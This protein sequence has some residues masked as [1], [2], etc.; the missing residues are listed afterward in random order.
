[1]G[2]LLAAAENSMIETMKYIYGINCPNDMESNLSNS[3]KAKLIVAHVKS[4]CGVCSHANW[5]V[6]NLKKSKRSLIKYVCIYV[7]LIYIPNCSALFDFISL[8]S[9]SLIPRLS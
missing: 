3:H 7:I 8:E 2:K 4:L 5:I 9:I 6:R 1:M